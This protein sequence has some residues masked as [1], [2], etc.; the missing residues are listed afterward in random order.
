MPWPISLQQVSSKLLL[1]N[2]EEF[3]QTL[4]TRT[5]QGFNLMA[6]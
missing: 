3:L 4:K 1:G 6:L 5:R 2:N